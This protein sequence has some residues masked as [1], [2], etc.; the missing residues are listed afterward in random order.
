[1][2]PAHRLLLAT[3]GGILSLKAVALATRRRPRGIGLP[4]FLFAWPGVIPDRF[5]ERRP[6]QIIDPERFLAAWARMALGAAS[7]ILLAVYTPNIPEAVLGL[8]GVGA[9]LLT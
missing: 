6:A 9:L 1:M 8:A 2:S 4:L 7:V 3:L 5:R